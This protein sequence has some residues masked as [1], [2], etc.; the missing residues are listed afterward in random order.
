MTTGN[1][2]QWT[3]GVSTS[4]TGNQ[5]NYY[6]DSQGLH[7]GVQS[8]G[9][10]TWINYNAVS[11]FVNAELF[12]VSLTN[13]NAVAA[14]G[15]FNP[16]F[17]VGG[18]N[19]DGIIGCVSWT[20]STGYYWALQTTTDAG[21]TWSTLWQAGPSTMPN[22]EDCTVVTNGSN[23]LQV[24]VGGSLVFSSTSMAL[25]M[26]SPL[27]VFFQDDSSSSAMSYATFYNYYA[28]T[29]ANVT[30]TDAPPGSTAEIVDAS[31]NVLAS[32]GVGSNGDASMPVG[33]YTMPLDGY[34]EVLGSSGVLLASTSAPVQVYGG[35]VYSVATP[36]LDPTSTAISPSPAS[37]TAGGTV[38]FT[39]TVT[40]TSASPTAPSGTISWSDGGAGGSFSSGTCSLQGTSSTGT[41]QVTYTT[42]TTAGSVTVTGSYSSDS[43]HS[44]SS[45]E[46]SVTVNA[47]PTYSIA[48]QSS[49]LVLFDPLDNVTMSQQQLQAQGRYYYGGDAQGEDA[50]YS[51]SEDSSGLHIGVQAPAQPQGTYAGFYAADL[52]FNQGEVFHATIAVPSSTI[53]SGYYNTGLYVQTGNGYIDYVFCGE[54][55]SSLG[56]YWGVSYATS[57]T[58]TSAT[59]FQNLWL[60]SSANQPL[61]RS[62]TIVTNGSNYLEV[63][64]D[65]V[66]VY[67][68]SA[69]NLQ[70]ARPFQTYLEVESSYSGAELSGTFTDFYVT[71]GTTVTLTDI[72]S[73]ATSVKLVD[74]AGDTLA[75]STVANGV[76][77]MDIGN[78][79]FPLSAKIVVQR[80]DGSSIVSS[81]VL[82]LAGGDTYT[83][84][85]S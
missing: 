35:D 75:N 66:L 7:I 19:Y 33:M 56:T 5:Y 18:S 24:Y 15:V 76:A 38:T 51:F 85:S 16:G 30:V 12:H 57:N 53:P 71:T 67:S 49:G 72:P 32:A 20:D 8:P 37:V 47:A 1:Y 80:E 45:G 3:F 41:C 29:G 43:T 59:N 25:N 63:Y 39:A 61:T 9:G 81:S 74:S 70:F 4:A 28:A 40:D 69:L 62:C 73:G 48:K 23:E 11:A 31:G 2:A 55:T 27:R 21:S 58:T 78:C 6:E 52:N 10:G 26:P 22:T 42:P 68:S 50:P 82:A 79:T 65:N 83:V 54:V 14:D 77:T 36:T 64:V 13:P 17:Y 34:V 44:A 84:F 60:D 46:S